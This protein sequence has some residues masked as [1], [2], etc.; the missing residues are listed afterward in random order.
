M[1]K[2]GEGREEKARERSKGRREEKKRKKR[3]IETCG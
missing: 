2:A 3:A 1:V